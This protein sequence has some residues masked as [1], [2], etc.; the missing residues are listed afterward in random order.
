[1]LGPFICIDGDCQAD[2]CL[3]TPTRLVPI[4]KPVAV[5]IERTVGRDVAALPTGGVRRNYS[6]VP[7]LSQFV[8]SADVASPVCQVFPSNPE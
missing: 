7:C 2:A 8:P 4:E 6:S 5:V 3:A 1:M